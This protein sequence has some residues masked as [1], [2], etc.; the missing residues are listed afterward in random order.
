MNSP[1]KFSVCLNE[2]QITHHEEGAIAC[3]QDFVRGPYF[4]QRSFFSQS[5]ISL[6][7]RVVSSASALCDGSAFDPWGSLGVCAG[8]TISDF[9]ACR[10]KVVLRRKTSKVSRERWFDVDSVVSSLVGEGTGRAGVRIS[11]RC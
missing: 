2:M 5:G 6:F 1:E 7:E 3:L 10:E 9:R 4:T 8:S 11:R